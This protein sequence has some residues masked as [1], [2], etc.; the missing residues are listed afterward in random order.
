MDGCME[1]KRS[2]HPETNPQA[3]AKRQPE[4]RMKLGDKRAANQ[5]STLTSVCALEGSQSWFHD[6][7][8]WCTSGSWGPCKMLVPGRLPRPLKPAFPGPDLG[9]C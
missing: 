5:A 4:S 3:V 7:H 1:G 6:S 2:H 9:I 8:T